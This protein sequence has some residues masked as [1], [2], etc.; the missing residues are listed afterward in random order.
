MN[1]EVNE[2]YSRF[3]EILDK[4]SI[5]AYKVAKETGVT[6]ATL[7]S[8]KQG[9]YIPKLDKMQKIANY[10]GVSTDYL[11]NGEDLE[12]LTDLEIK[13][14]GI[15]ISEIM[16]NAVKM[17]LVGM[18]KDFPDEEMQNLIDFAKFRKQMH[19]QV[20]KEEKKKGK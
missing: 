12:I 2:S 4:K 20:E 16:A 7:T 3:Q 9:K 1:N 19:E 5:T 18:L 10:L 17:E 8:W 11:I 6:T 14:A 13:R 15:S